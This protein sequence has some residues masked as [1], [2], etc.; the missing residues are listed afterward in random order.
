MSVQERAADKSNANTS[1]Q[2]SPDSTG[3]VSGGGI[4]LKEALRGQDYARQVQL[5]VPD[6]AGVGSDANVQ[7]A[8]TRGISGGGS[9]LPHTEQIQRSFGSHDISKVQA[10]TGGKADDATAT[11]GANAYATGNHV[12]LGE[13]GKDLHTTAHEAAHVVQQR[14]GVSLSGGVG[15]AGDSYEQHADAVADTVVQGKSSEGLLDQMTGGGASDV[16][17]KSGAAVQRDPADSAEWNKNYTDLQTSLIWLFNR[18]AS[19]A[20]SWET[21][22]KKVDPPPAWQ[23]ALKIV[24]T[25]ALSA[26]LGGLGGALAGKLI[27]ATTKFATQFLINAAIEA[28][29]KAVEEGVGLAAAGKGSDINPV[30]AFCDQQAVSMARAGTGASQGLSDQ[31]GDAFKQKLSAKNMKEMALA[32]HAKGDDKAAVHREMLVGLMNFQSVGG[33]NGDKMKSGVNLEDTSLKGVLGLVISGKDDN[34]TGILRAEADGINADLKG[35]LTGTVGEWISGSKRK[36]G[37]Q[38]TVKPEWHGFT[39]SNATKQQAVKAGQYVGGTEAKSQSSI[40]FAFGRT[41]NGDLTYTDQDADST[42]D[43][44]WGADAGRWFLNNVKSTHAI[45]EQLRG[46]KLPAVT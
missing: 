39:V 34:P 16:Q 19:Y 35:S 36:S 4:Q 23:T 30:A 3:T 22:A 2:V 8:A 25:V 18:Q 43:A 14:A 21:I 40:Y 12:V 38:L 10:H 13:G 33:T 11:M 27:T 37:L 32:N 5:L 15:R 45:V 26:A 46:F 31:A 9:R 24:G 29:K 41:A 17:K 20:R 44:N 6:G 1:T 28:G 42:L 7:A